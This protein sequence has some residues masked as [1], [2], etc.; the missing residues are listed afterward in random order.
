MAGK[1]YT[2]SEY[3]HPAPNDYR[4]ETLPELATFAAFQDWDAI[5]LFDY[6]DYG[7]SVQNDKIN[8]FFGISSDPTKTAFLPAA[9]MIFR[10]GEIPPASDSVIA[11]APRSQLAMLPSAGSAWSAALGKAGSS[12]PFGERL[13]LSLSSKSVPAISQ[14]QLLSH[15][16]VSVSKTEAGALYTASAPAALACA[17]YVGGQTVTLGDNALAFPAFGNNFAAVTLTAMDQKPLAQS[18]K[19][20]LTLLG[21]VEN[22]SMGWNSDR[23]SVG[24]QWGHGPTVA[25]GIPATVTL[26]TNS[27]RHVW[28]LDGT[29]QRVGDVPATYANGSLTFNVG[30]QY[31]TLWYEVGE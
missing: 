5:Y 31:K 20:L 22:Q 18:Q 29:G 12:S 7:T 2:V 24:N 6:G 21:K 4:A 23:T 11:T 10:A 28:A 25:E 26:K 14:N 13:S 27:T 17:G 3:N 15:P 8:G 30:P 9:A 16:A 1:P 19:L